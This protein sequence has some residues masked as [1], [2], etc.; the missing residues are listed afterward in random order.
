MN[1]TFVLDISKQALITAAYILVPLLGS[2]LIVGVL[3]S[4][5]QTVTQIQEMTLTFVPKIAV[6]GLV[7]LALTPWFLQILMQFTREV[8]NQIPNMV[9]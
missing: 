4:L 5:F 9:H 7:L 6:V 2:G 8:F 3:I 1:I